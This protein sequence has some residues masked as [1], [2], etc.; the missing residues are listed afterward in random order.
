MTDRA[1]ASQSVAVSQSRL[2]EAV[3]GNPVSTS[4]IVRKR[5]E[6]P[7][8]TRNTRISQMERD[9]TRLGQPNAQLQSR[10]GF[11]QPSQNLYLQYV[12]V[13]LRVKAKVL[14]GHQRFELIQPAQLSR[15]HL[16]VLIP[17]AERDDEQSSKTEK[18]R[19]NFSHRMKSFC[20]SWKY[21]NPYKIG[22]SARRHSLAATWGIVRPASCLSPITP[23]EN[24][25]N[26]MR[27][28]VYH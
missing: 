20:N 9:E 3:F 22:Y 10:T 13:H 14:A 21:L 6:P 1:F 8:T 7:G 25:L 4:R 26:I 19:V 23:A 24:L 16:E 18:H 11:E 17:N 12:A 28:V 27:Y 15:N 2:G 5:I